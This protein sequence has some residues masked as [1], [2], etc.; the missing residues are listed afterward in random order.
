[1]AL[2]RKCDRCGCYFDYIDFTESRLTV[3]QTCLIAPDILK[4]LC[5][6]C[7]EKLREFMEEKDG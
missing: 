1:M 5:P 7:T 3:V 2:A 6:D 4:D